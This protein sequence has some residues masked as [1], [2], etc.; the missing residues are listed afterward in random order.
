MRIFVSGR[1]ID[2]PT[3]ANGRINIEEVLRAANIPNRRTLIQQ[4]QTGENTILPKRGV[5]RINPY[6]HF[7]DAPIAKRGIAS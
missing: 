1:E 4:N 2:L 6:D 3:D 5:V 7:I